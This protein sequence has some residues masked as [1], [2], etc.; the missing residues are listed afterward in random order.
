LQLFAG[1]LELN[2]TRTVFYL[3]QSGRC[4]KKEFLKIDFPRVPYPKTLSKFRTLTKLGGEL[5]QLHLLE[6]PTVEKY[7][8]QYPIDGSNV[9]GKPKYI[10]ISKNE[11]TGLLQAMLILTKRNTFP[12]F[13]SVYVRIKVKKKRE[14]ILVKNT[15]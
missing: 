3:L 11:T 4:A 14:H 15:L 12:T 5:R 10:P 6:S 1:S 2:I 9:L 13:H 7:I 8:T